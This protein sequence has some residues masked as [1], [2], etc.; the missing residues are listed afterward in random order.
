MSWSDAEESRIAAL[1]TLLNKVQIAVTNLAAK[2]QLRQLT[3]LKQNEVDALTT[4]IEAL[5]RMVTL[6]EN[7][8]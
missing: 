2:Q 3:L 4:R 8:L 1:E 6:L 5:E 7:A